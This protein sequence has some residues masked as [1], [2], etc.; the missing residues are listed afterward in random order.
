MG[1]VLGG[2]LSY[3]FAAL[4][5]RQLR[6][7]PPLLMAAAQVTCLTIMLLPLAAVIDRFW[8]AASPRTP[9]I[10]AIFGLAAFGTALAYIVFF[11]INVPPDPATSCL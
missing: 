4:W 5:M 2:A 11:R 8:G 6:R 3:A 9:A 10:V 7:I 1:C